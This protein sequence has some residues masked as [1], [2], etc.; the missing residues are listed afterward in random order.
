MYKLHLYHNNKLIISLV[1]SRGLRRKPAQSYI[2]VYNYINRCLRDVIQPNFL[3]CNLHFNC[4]NFNERFYVSHGLSVC[5]SA[6]EQ[7]GGR[8]GGRA[9]GGGGGVGGG[10]GGTCARACVSLCL[11]VSPSSVAHLALSVVT[12]R[13]RDSTATSLRR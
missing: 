11:I 5:V 6:S 7:A 10:G 9:G 3:Y 2:I 4:C 13:R 8:A 12:P 1:C